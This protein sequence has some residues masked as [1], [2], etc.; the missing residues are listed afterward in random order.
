MAATATMAAVSVRKMFLPSVTGMHPFS[1]AVDGFGI[2][3]T[4]FWADKER[5]GW[6]AVMFF[7]RLL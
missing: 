4:A 5:N 2:R 3:K 7:V 1:I 6:L